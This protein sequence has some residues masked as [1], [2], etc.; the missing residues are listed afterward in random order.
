[1]DSQVPYTPLYTTQLAPGRFTTTGSI[2]VNTVPRT[3]YVS[4]P[5]DWMA[6]NFALY[7][8]SIGFRLKFVK[9]EFHSGRLLVYFTPS[10]SLTLFNLE[11]SMPYMHREIVDLRDVNEFV[12]VCPWA[13]S[14]PYKPVANVNSS[15]VIVTTTEKDH[16]GIFGFAVLNELVHPDTVT[17]SIQ[18]IVEQFCH[19][20]FEFQCPV[21]SAKCPWFGATGPSA[22]SGQTSLPNPTPQVGELIPNETELQ[23]PNNLDVPIGGSKVLLDGNSSSSTCVGENFVSLRQLLKRHAVWATYNAIPANPAGT[24]GLLFIRPHYMAVPQV[25]FTNNNVN[26]FVTPRIDFVMTYCTLYAYMRGSMRVK[27]YPRTATNRTFRA[28]LVS[29]LFNNSINTGVTVSAPGVY[30]IAQT[31]CTNAPVF[32]IMPENPMEMQIPYYSPTHTTAIV[33]GINGTTPMN[34]FLY[35]RAFARCNIVQ[36]DSVAAGTP[37]LFITRQIGEDFSFGFFLGTT[38]LIDVSAANNGDIAQAI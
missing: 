13:S 11:A 14:T 10:Q 5:M 35:P 23:S 27:V 12:F 29:E 8:G 30:G 18:I 7:R 17:P 33:H 25:G 1:L 26:E 4:P 3:T 28:E 22:V 9:T 37:D 16:Y 19:S 36:A 20:D 34:T 2:T 24:P 21:P 38:L 15:S 32:S 6:N 31:N